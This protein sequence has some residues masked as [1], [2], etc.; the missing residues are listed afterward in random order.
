MKSEAML[1]WELELRG[2]IPAKAS[3]VPN[4]GSLEKAILRRGPPGCP[5]KPQAMPT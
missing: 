5:K 4:E 2:A 3:L 1:T